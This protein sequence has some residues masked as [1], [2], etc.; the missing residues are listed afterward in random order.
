MPDTVAAA[1]PPD[2]DARITWMCRQVLQRGPRGDELSS[3]RSLVEKH[4]VAREGSW[5]A[6]R[7]ADGSPAGTSHTSMWQGAYH[8]GRSMLL[9]AKLL[10]DLA[11]SAK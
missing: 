3:L 9:S 8:N 4:Q 10:D 11:A 5:W 7:K 6:T 1:A 2:R